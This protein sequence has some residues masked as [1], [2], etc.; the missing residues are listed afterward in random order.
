M[1][2]ATAQPRKKSKEPHLLSEIERQQAVLAELPS[3]YEFPL[4]DGRQAIESQRKSGYKNTAR[5]A[6]EIVDNAYEAG[7]KNVHIVFKRPGEDKRAK[8]ERRDSIAEVAFIDDG[9][10]MVP[11][12]ARYALSWGGG[13]HF[14]DPTGIGRFGFGLLNSSIN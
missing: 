1:S 6:R 4:F 11:T 14:N 3:D 8:G 9:P 5:A 12:M 7:A 13:T 2:A 10:G